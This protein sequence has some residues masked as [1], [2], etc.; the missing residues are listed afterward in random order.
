MT[1]GM[2]IALVCRE[3]KWTYQ[4]FQDQPSEFI[5]TV[6]DMCLAEFEAKEK[7]Q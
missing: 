7:A 2:M 1:E 3:M 5:D 4:E 6:I